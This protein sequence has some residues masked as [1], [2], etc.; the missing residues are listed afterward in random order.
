[1]AHYVDNK[2]FLEALKE[3]KLKC[4]EA[5]EAGLR[6][7]RLNNYIG[8]C[9]LLIATRVSYRPNFINYSY[10]DEMIS[11]GIE[12]CIQYISSFDPDK[13]D[14][15]FAYFTQVIFFAF[16]RRINKE[17]RQSY[18]RSKLIQDMSFDLFELQ[19]HDEGGVFQN[20]YIEYMQN[21]PPQEAPAVK[22]KKR[23]QQI[24]D[25]GEFV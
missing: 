21:N 5:E 16:I 24:T 17:K 1:M 6:K 8:E 3:Y 15:P 13:S 19:E 10:R 7:P 2:D 22:R 25:L 14:N 12:N 23:T 18:I 9:I 11:D 4:K 20:T